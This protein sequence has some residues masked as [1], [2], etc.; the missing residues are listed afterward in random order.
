MNTLS[1]R[2]NKYPLTNG[3]Y[4]AKKY[5]LVFLV[6]LKLGFEVANFVGQ[7]FDLL[8]WIRRG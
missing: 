4:I 3:I 1:Y 2:L 5:L 8:P 6:P 7:I